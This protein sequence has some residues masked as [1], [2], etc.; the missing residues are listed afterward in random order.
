MSFPPEQYHVDAGDVNG[1]ADGRYDWTLSRTHVDTRL[2][3]E[4]DPG[5]DRLDVL[6]S[7]TADTPGQAVDA[8]LATAA[9]RDIAIDYV[10]VQL[11]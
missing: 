9:K 7:G 8:C 3:S 10:F 11:D 4:D 1:R 2:E 6:N 5:F